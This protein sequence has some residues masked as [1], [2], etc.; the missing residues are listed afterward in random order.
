MLKRRHRHRLWCFALDARRTPQ[1]WSRRP[2]TRHSVAGPPLAVEDESEAVDWV[3][4]R[5]RHWTAGDRFSLAVVESQPADAS[6]RLVDQVVVKGLALGG[7][8][9]KWATGPRRTHAAARWRRA[10][11]PRSPVEGSHVSCCRPPWHRLWFGVRGRPGVKPTER[12]RPRRLSSWCG[13]GQLWKPLD[14]THAIARSSVVA[15]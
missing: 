7:R 1:R 10:R 8:L 3:R 14:V 5:Q 11:W 6:G 9:L 2:V 15:G 13:D 12:R 4:G